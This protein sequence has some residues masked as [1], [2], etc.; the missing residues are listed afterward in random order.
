MIQ[1]V[2][3]SYHD[4]SDC[5]T[6]LAIKICSS[7]DNAK[8]VIL[9]NVCVDFDGKWKTLKGAARELNRDLEHCYWDEEEK[10]FTWLDNGKGESYIICELDRCETK[11][12]N[13]GE[14]A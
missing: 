14:I 2:R 13:I 1:I 7:I 12:Q 5:S 4:D 8:K 3:F 11:W 9:A 6:S 10:T